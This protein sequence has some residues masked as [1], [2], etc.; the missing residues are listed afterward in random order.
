MISYLQS[1][2]DIEGKVILVT[3][4]GQGIGKAI[5]ISMAKCGATV[6]LSGRNKWK[7]QDVQEECHKLAPD[8]T[9]DVLVMDITNE[10]S[11]L[12]GFAYIRDKYHRL[13]VVI[14]DAG[15]TIPQNAEKLTL[16]EWDPVINTNLTGTFI[17]CREAG[18]MMIEQKHGKIINLISTYAFVGRYLRAAY[19]AS[20]GGILQLSKTL[21]IEWAQYN[22]NVNCIAPT[23]T[24]S[25]MT[26]R[27][28]SNPEALDQM[29]KKIPMG[30]LA[31]AEDMC[32]AAIYLASAASDF[33]TGQAIA[34]DGGFLAL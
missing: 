22:I 25:P 17:C 23:A 2:F 6:I 26:E 34:V 27:L 18:K 8:G 9:T 24:V 19:S 21:A 3:G 10:E 30:R 5:S 29:L 15:I 11:I 7:L 4:A 28:T 20:K 32:G 33:V 12:Q 16:K 31:T 14:N 13:D 1:M